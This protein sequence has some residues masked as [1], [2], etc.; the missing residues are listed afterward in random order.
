M[1]FLY[2][3]LYKACSAANA[4]KNKQDLQKEVNIKRKRFES[5]ENVKDELESK[6]KELMRPYV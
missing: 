1:I 3:K 6:I 2:R 4:N 5:V